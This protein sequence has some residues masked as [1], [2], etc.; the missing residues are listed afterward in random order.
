[1]A[2]LFPV[3][4]TIIQTLTESKTPREEWPPAAKRRKRELDA[5]F[6]A[7][8]LKNRLP[9]DTLSKLTALRGQL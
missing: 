8:Q 5:I 7:G 2:Q 3:V 9:Q 1:M 6:K 4:D